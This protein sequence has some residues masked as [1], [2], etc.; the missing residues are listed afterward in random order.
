VSAYLYSAQYFAEQRAKVYLY[1][2]LVWSR[3]PG[4]MLDSWLCMPTHTIVCEPNIPTL[5]QFTRA[6]P[7]SWAVYYAHG[8]RCLCRWSHLFVVNGVGVHSLAFSVSIIEPLRI[9]AWRSAIGC[10]LRPLSVC[11][12][13]LSSIQCECIFVLCAVLCGATCKSVS[14]RDSCM[15][16]ASG[17]NVGLW[18]YLWHG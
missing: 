8:D 17:F 9:D 4:L 10:V 16:Q 11:E 14:L 15:E 1:R 3:H 5:G 6:C 2:I 12:Q 7:I 18:R 13:L